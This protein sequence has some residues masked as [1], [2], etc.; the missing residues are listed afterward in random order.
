MGKDMDR[1][2]GDGGMLVIE[3]I[4]GS[5][6]SYGDGWAEGKWVPTKMACNPHDGVQAGVYAV[7]LDAAMNFAINASLDGKDRTKAT[8]EMKTD[9]L[10]GAVLGE[11]LHVRGQLDR[12]TKV[13]AFSSAEIRN[14]AGDL[15]CRSTGTFMVHRAEP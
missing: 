8:L 12:M 5:I 7:M 1:W 10:K 11:T 14:E 13:I 9:C 3:A 4:G 2:L 6:D 15:I